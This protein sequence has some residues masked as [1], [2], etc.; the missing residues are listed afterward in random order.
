MLHACIYMYEYNIYYE[1]TDYWRYQWHQCFV[2]K[3][4]D[5]DYFGSD[6]TYNLQID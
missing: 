5:I 1:W 3:N 4:V 2:F 6:A